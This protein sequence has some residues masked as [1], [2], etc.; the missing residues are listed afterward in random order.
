MAISSVAV[1][2]MLGILLVIFQYGIWRFLQ[3]KDRNTLPLEICGFIANFLVI[4]TLAWAY[5]S[6]A[7]REFQAAGM[8]FV[9]FGGAALIPIIITYRLATRKKRVSQDKAAENT[10]L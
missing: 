6:L 5:A 8:G 10:S 7:E 2:L 3:S 4:F 9:F 1:W